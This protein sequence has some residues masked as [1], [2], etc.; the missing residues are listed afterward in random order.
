MGKNEAELYLTL[1]HP[2]ITHLEM[3]YEDQ[4]ML[5]LVMEH[6]AGGEV[7]DR[8]AACKKY[9]EEKAAN[10]IHQMLLAVAYLHSRNIAHRDL[11]LENFLYERPDAEHLKL[12]DFGF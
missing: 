7:Y 1:D 4:D 12:I 3:I 8:L 5:H 11:K 9:T 10:T 6:M 2:H